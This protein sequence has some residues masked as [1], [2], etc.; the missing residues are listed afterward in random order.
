MTTGRLDSCQPE[1][2][3]WGLLPA[4]TSP[5]QAEFLQHGMVQAKSLSEGLMPVEILTPGINPDEF[6]QLGYPG[7]MLSSDSEAGLNGADEDIS[8]DDKGPPELIPAEILT[9]G[10]MPAETLPLSKNSSD[11]K[12]KDNFSDDEGPTPGLMPAE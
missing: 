2:L 11:R 9:S 10:I 6:L 4:G 5:W 8:L 1:F 7:L 12:G 3:P